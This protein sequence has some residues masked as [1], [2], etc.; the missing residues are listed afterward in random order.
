M[1]TK[2]KMDGA[3]RAFLRSVVFVLCVLGVYIYIAGVITEIS[4]QGNRGVAAAGVG[5]EQGRE[6]FFGK[7]KCSTC[8]SLG[9]EGSAVRCPNLGVKD[10][11]GP[12]FDMPII[13]RAELRAK[14]RTAKTGQPYTATDYI[15]ES[16]FEPG[17]Y[18]VEGY[19]NEMPVIWKPPIALSADEEISVDSFLQSLG[20]E[21]DLPAITGSPIFA[22]IKR[23]IKSLESEPTGGGFALYL[24]GDAARGE[25]IFFDP[26]SPTPCAKCHTIKGQGGK[27][28]P[29]LTN[30]AGSRTPQYIV[31][32]V[33]DP[34]K[35]IA[36][37]FEP[38][39]V[40]TK[41]GDFI[42]GV[43]KGE[44]AESFEILDDQGELRKIPKA[45]IQEIVPQK[46]SIMPGN[47][48]EIL[49]M[50]QF[51]DVVAFLLTLT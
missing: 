17:A 5:P 42:T 46:I 40:E 45:E 33:L 18:V 49:T 10:G 4:G 25:Q 30:V 6:V 23:G 39:L 34:S 31:E 1:E 41:A 24:T 32:S 12:P 16:H 29:E 51:H 7:G 37:G 44:D 43:K 11:A 36:S 50:E 27:V 8:H 38:F 21:A 13:Q 9:T 35:E 2:K 26:D 14:E 15:L 19:K 28:G 3:T 22:K 20:G 47:F 48:R